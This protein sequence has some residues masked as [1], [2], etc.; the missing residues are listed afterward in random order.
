MVRTALAK[1]PRRS[2]VEVRHLLLASAVGWLTLFGAAPAMGEPAPARDAAGDVI[3]D[4]ASD[5]WNK[6]GEEWPRWT[7]HDE[8]NK[9][10]VDYSTWKEFMADYADPHSKQGA[11]DFVHVSMR[12]MGLLADYIF[13]LEKVPVSTLPRDEQLAYWLNLHNAA[14]VEATALSLRAI[15]DDHDT[16]RVLILGN[17]WREK[18]LTVEGEALSLVDIERRIVMR[19]WQDPRV[20]YGLYMPALGAPSLPAAPFTGTTVWRSLDNRARE[21]VNSERA[22]E[23]HGGQLHISGLYY[24]DHGL[25]PNDAAI[26]AHLRAFAATPLRT[27]LEKIQA[28]TATYLNWRINSFNSGYDRHQDHNGSAC[29]V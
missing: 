23:L 8:T 13:K 12:G 6:E 25:F 20:L 24:W 27:K 19:Q 1:N 14:A 10:G 4:N 28:V 16:T 7:A 21:F 3:I 29:P 17:R 9:V 18:T 15:Y 22:L 2:G 26:L 5:L 11:L